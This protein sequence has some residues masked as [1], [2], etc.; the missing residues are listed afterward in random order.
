MMHLIVISGRYN[1]EENAMPNQKTVQNV[2]SMNSLLKELSELLQSDPNIDTAALAKYL[3][4]IASLKS[5]ADSFMSA[6]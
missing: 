4:L 3:Q 1:T 5:V 6:G 2:N